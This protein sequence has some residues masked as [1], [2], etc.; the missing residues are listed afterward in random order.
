MHFLFL[1]WLSQNPSLVDTEEGNQ[2]I[3]AAA[4]TLTHDTS[5]VLAPYERSLLNMVAHQEMT[6]SHLLAYLREHEQA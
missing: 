3:I 4:L 1:L 2:Q 6:L 5:R